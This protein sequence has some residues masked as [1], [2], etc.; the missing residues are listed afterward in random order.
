MLSQ[1]P[2][3]A[4]DTGRCGIAVKQRET[5]NVAH[6][7]MNNV[8]VKDD[9]RD[10]QNRKD[11]CECELGRTT[12]IACTS[13]AKDFSHSSKQSSQVSDTVLPLPSTQQPTGDFPVKIKSHVS[14]SPIC[15]HYY[16]SGRA[17]PSPKFAICFLSAKHLAPVSVSGAKRTAKSSCNK[18][19]QQQHHL[20]LTARHHKLQKCSQ[21]PTRVDE[22]AHYSPPQTLKMNSSLACH[23]TFLN[24][25]C[26][27][28][29]YI[30]LTMREF[31]S[32]RSS[33]QD[34]MR[35]LITCGMLSID[36]AVVMMWFKF[37]PE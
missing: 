25:Y 14:T 19:C 27:P 9:N 20:S 4:E 10:L 33:H 36:G 16:S 28:G 5:E 37:C 17:E 24:T 6:C 11:A 3:N 13:K 21:Y 22:L 15:A 29:S 26:L 2:H 18:N 34:E 31:T 32:K 12:K 30:A 35:S 1:L 23:G 8:N 7:I